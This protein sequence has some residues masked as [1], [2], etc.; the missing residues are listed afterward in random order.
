M[1]YNDNNYPCTQIKY[2]YIGMFGGKWWKL[3]YDIFYGVATL[4]ALWSY[5]AL[6]GV[7]L[8]RNIGIT[9]ISDACDM[10]LDAEDREEGCRGL[11]SLYVSIFW[12]WTLIVSLMDFSEQ[13]A[14]QI[15]ATGARILIISL[16][17]FTS[18]G[19]IYSS[20]YYDGEAYQLSTIDL[21][22][23]YAEGTLAWK[24]SG[25]AYMIAV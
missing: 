21:S 20:W 12:I 14:I 8:A 11:Y 23:K 2:I 6:F 7:S 16:M 25:M 10:S 24:W 19:L 15:F 18:I 4:I 9:G 3:S 17:I 22:G 13:Q 5:S 1:I